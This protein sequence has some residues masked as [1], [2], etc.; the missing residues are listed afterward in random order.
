MAR[1]IHL[2]NMGILVTSV[3]N[4][5]VLDPLVPR[6]WKRAP[7]MRRSAVPPPFRAGRLAH[8]V[9]RETLFVTELSLSC[10]CGSRM[11]LVCTEL[12]S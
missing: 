11:K 8:F 10:E 7:L 3:T 6:F 5:W 9:S 1:N 2:R 12:Q 4:D